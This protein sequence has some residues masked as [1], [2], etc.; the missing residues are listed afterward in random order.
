MT[1]QP[2]QPA[3][4]PRAAADSIDGDDLGEPVREAVRD[5]ARPLKPGEFL[6]RNGEI[7]ALKRDPE[8][9]MFYI[10]PELM[11]KDYTYEWKR[12][13]VIG[14]PDVTHQVHLAENGWRAVLVEKGSRWEGHF[15][16]TGYQGPIRREG[17]MLMERPKGMTDMVRAQEKARANSQLRDSFD[18]YTRR[19]GAVDV[20]RGFAAREGNIQSGYDIGPAP[21]RPEAGHKID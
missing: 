20:P 2:R 6:G 7:L 17:N 15:M 9:D 12:E 14:V 19:R 8:R 16:P 21:E 13:T 4:K 11:D 1:T 3:R 5:T 10:P 18:K